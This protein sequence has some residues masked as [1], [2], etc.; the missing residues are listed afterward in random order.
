GRIVEL[1]SQVVEAV[2]GPDGQQ[3]AYTVPGAG[4]T[5]LMGIEVDLRARYR[6]AFEPGLV[7]GL[8]WSPD[9][10][11]LAYS[12]PGLAPALRRVRVLSLTGAGGAIT[13][14]R[15]DTTQPHW[16]DESHLV[17]AA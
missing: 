8:A 3:V 10:L 15:G 6:L 11:R 7:S 5:D 1:A 12:L 14:A 16:L 13:V 2:L 4:G 17:F 9:G